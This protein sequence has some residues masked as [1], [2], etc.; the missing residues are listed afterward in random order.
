MDGWRQVAAAGGGV[1]VCATGGWWWKSKDGDKRRDVEVWLLVWLLVWLVGWQQ[2]RGLAGH[3]HRMGRG[4]CRCRYY[5]P[6]YRCMGSVRNGER[7]ARAS[8][9][10]RWPSSLSSAG[11]RVGEGV[12]ANGESCATDR[13][14][15]RVA[16]QRGGCSRTQCFVFCVFFGGCIYARRRKATG[17]D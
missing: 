4:E 5:L 10:E 14:R 8:S 1:A 7:V 11:R 17:E 16:V 13:R 2:A 9:L 3:V 6:T 12:A 15:H